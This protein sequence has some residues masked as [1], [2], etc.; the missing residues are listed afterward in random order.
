[1]FEPGAKNRNRN[2]LVKRSGPKR[3]GGVCT[4]QAA[5]APLGPAAGSAGEFLGA[6]DGGF[7]CPG[8]PQEAHWDSGEPFGWD[9][10]L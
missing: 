8:G 5:H 4:G 6:G 10:G 1:M 2:R 9:P 3:S 7:H